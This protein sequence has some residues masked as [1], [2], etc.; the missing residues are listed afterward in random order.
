MP[1]LTPFPSKFVKR[2][3]PGSNNRSN[4]FR[5][6][7]D[8]SKGSKGL[9]SVPESSVE[10]KIVKEYNKQ[11][12]E[13]QKMNLDGVKKNDDLIFDTLEKLK[14]KRKAPSQKKKKGAKKNSRKS[15]SKK[16]KKSVEPNFS[17]SS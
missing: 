11:G 3:V 8:Q 9:L 4:L 10:E 2:S 1:T 12:E 7:P 17:I 16:F 6:I 13:A 5:R 14:S 15:T